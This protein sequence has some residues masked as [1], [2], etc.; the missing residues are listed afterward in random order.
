[1]NSAQLTALRNDI[2][3]NTATIG[4]VQ[5]NAMPNNPDA[6]FAI[7]AWYSGVATPDFVVWQTS[8][9]IDAIQDAIVYANMTP[10]AA[11]DGTQTW[12]NRAL[13]CQGKQFN[14]QNL[15]LGRATVNASKANIRAAFQDCLTALPSKADGT[16]QAAGWTSVQTAMQRLATRIEKLFATG[17]GSAASPATM[18]YEGF[19]SGSEV[20]AA[21]AN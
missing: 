7:A 13:Q 6:N 16:N 14:L 9:S 11:P 3:A 15:L 2:A 1:M 8:V 17:T 10:A 12:A 21:R 18:A 5:I 4:G 19:V 20:D